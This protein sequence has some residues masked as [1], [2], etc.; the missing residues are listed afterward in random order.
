[1]SDTN[2]LIEKSIKLRKIKE[3]LERSD[4]MHYISET[5]DS[6]SEDDAKQLLSMFVYAR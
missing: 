2:D 6:L 1:M 3:E 5:I 4:S